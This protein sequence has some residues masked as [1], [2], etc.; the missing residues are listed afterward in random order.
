MTVREWAPTTRRYVLLGTVLYI[1][2]TA[3]VTYPQVRLMREGVNDVGD[4]LLNTW[5]LAWVAH[6]LPFAPAH[7][8]DGNIFHP[9]KRTLAYSET[10]LAPAVIGAPL[11]YAG[12]GPILVYNLLLFASFVFTGLGMALLVRELT[13]HAVA[14][15]IAGTMC[16]FLPYRF[17]HYAHFQLLQMQWIPL[18]LWALHRLLNDGR[19]RYGVALGLFVGAQGLTSM[20]NAI[21]LGTFLAVVGGV[22]LALD[23]GRARER[24]RP[25]LA[26]MVIAGVL[27]SPVVIVHARARDVVG[28]RSRGDAIGG[29]A[30]WKNFLA[31]PPNSYM[32]ARWSRSFG[33][34]ERKLFPGVMALVCAAIGLWPP[35]NRVRAA[36]VVGGLVSAQ[37]A[38]GLNGWLFGLL[39]DYV[40]PFRSLRVPA[41]MG[42]MVSIAV[43]V[44]AGYG[45]ARLLPHVRASWRPA[46][47]AVLGAL[48]LLDSWVAPLSLRRVATTAPETY[49]DLRR[50]KGDPPEVSFVRR[51]SDPV[52]AVL[53]EFPISRED[54]TLMY[55]S[56][57]H[58]QQLVN[59]YSGFFPLSYIELFNQTAAFPDPSTD[60]AL[61]RRGVRYVTVHGEMM[62][63]GEY[64]RMIAAIDARPNDFRLISRRPW[65]GSEIS[66]YYFFPDMKQ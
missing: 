61:L 22:L 38:L 31:A 63:E 30:E 1:V 62:R 57:F 44:L 26:S 48:V 32:H 41:R 56:T 65:H 24:W 13:G 28:E 39:F 54:P 2:L 46:A 10:L 45:I 17:D 53:L 23:L 40:L 49:A 29:S 14:G 60:G 20:Y 12:A 27:V 19:L 43:V 18:A 8:F 25:I 50:D 34:A 37:I 6:Q 52:P 47:A 11:L 35:W 7:V 55:Y 5:A 36:Y 51:L 16:A 4:P 59:G 15:L 21:F 33:D 9:E 3:A 66:L 64:Q 42:M 58:W